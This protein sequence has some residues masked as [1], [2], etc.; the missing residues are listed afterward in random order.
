MGADTVTLVAV[1]TAGSPA[2]LAEAAR[3]AAAAGCAVVMIPLAS[4]NPS[5]A[6]L[7]F[8]IAEFDAGA[9]APG[10][11]LT[12][13]ELDVFTAGARR[14]GLDVVPS[15]T[16]EDGL[17]LVRGVPIAA[18]HLPAAALLDLPLV[19]AGAGSGVPLWLDTAMA[20]LDEVGDAVAT[21]LKAGARATLLHGLA[22]APGRTEELNLRALV[23]LRERYALAVGFQAREATP[24]PVVAA[25]ALGA[26]VIAVPF[27]A[28]GFDATGLAALA[29]DARVVARALGD[30]D[31][32]VQA[33]E[34]AERDR[35]HP[36]LVARVDIA[37]G[38]TLTTELLTT[39]RPGIGLKPR[40]VGG[41]VGR[42][43]VV[44]IPAGTL[45]TL[46]MIE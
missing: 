39:G 22:T 8:E 2:S 41:V 26:T 36:S 24:A 19:A 35:M 7:P 43:A 4:S 45:I 17:A 44:D 9:G 13:A 33:S 30:G 37:R 29:S 42:R 32:R 20:T 5:A 10:V 28:G 40:A 18:L 15:I 27:G 34:W 23:T 25:V 11:S 6:T 14:Q 12:R 38:R 31:K 3:A 46:G 1:L 16:D 21:A